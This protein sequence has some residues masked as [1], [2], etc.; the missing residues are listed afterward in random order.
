MFLLTGFS[1]HS[2]DC[3]LNFFPFFFFCLC[4]IRGILRMPN[5]L[6]SLLIIL[7]RSSVLG[8][9]LSIFFVKPSHLQLSIFRSF[10]REKPFVWRV[11]L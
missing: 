11:N 10:L 7:I 8:L 2:I 4:H 1:P 6:V 3:F 9:L 5:H